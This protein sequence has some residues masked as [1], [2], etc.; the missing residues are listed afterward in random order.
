[1]QYEEANS[2]LST[3]QLKALGVLTST[4]E[5]GVAPMKK[6]PGTRLLKVERL[7]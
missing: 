1:M 5:V 3:R 4:P 6:G 7:P 2:Q